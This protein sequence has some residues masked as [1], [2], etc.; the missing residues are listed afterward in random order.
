MRPKLILI[1]TACALSIALPAAAQGAADAPA[2]PEPSGPAPTAAPPSETLA[3]WYG[4]LAWQFVL[5]SRQELGLSEAQV[6]SLEHLGADFLREAIHRQA[7]LAVAHL[8]L[9]VVLGPDPGDATR[10]V[11]MAKAEAKIREIE[12]ITADLEIAHLRMI[13]AVKAQLTAEQRSALSALL[14]VPPVG[15]ASDP[16][17]TARGSAGDRPGTAGGGGGSRPGAPSRRGGG[18]HPGTPPGSHPGTPSRPRVQ[19]HRRFE[20]RI[21]GRVFGGP[22]W[23]PY[24]SFPPYEVYA[25]PPVIVQGPPV[26]AQ[27]AP[28]AYWYYCPSARAY[29]PYVQSCPEPWLAV[30]PKTE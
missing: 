29:Y 17:T 7:D 18:A 20:P 26:Y 9:A 25:P 5:D 6:E 13:E 3:Y 2:A 23:Y 8:D 11:D 30:V 15:D 27:P 14:G 4:P 21:H 10:L 12:R 16:A 19:D 28:P 22:L 24:W 1:A